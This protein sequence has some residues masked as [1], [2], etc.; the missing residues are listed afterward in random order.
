MVCSSKVM[1][2][3][4]CR[5]AE[6]NFRE[7]GAEEITQ[8]ILRLVQS[9]FRRLIIKDIY[10]KPALLCPVKAEMKMSKTALKSISA[11]I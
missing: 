6:M 11:A 4:G 3:F 2:K 9:L 7:S 10:L 1:F 5:A 8:R